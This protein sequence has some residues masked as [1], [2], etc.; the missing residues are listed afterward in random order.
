MRYTYRKYQKKAKLIGF[1][2]KDVLWLQN[3][4]DE[5]IHDVYEESHIH[6]G[7]IYS[8][9]KSFHPLSTSITGYFQDSDTKKW[10]KV[11]DGMAR[12]PGPSAENEA[13]WMNSLEELLLHEKINNG[14]Q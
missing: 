6:H 7:I 2:G 9:Q 14:L 1:A 8:V 5:W 4:H 3:Q 12:T 11:K 10:I 13:G